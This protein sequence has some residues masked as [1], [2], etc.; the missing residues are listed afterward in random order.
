[1]YLTPPK[2]YKNKKFKAESEESDSIYLTLDELEKIHNFSPTFED[3]RLITKEIREHNLKRKLEVIIHDKNAFLIGTFTLQRVSDYSRIKDFNFQRDFIR[4]K[5]IKGSSKN[6]D[7]VV[8]R[9]WIITEIIESGF[10]FN[11]PTYDQKINANIK[12]VG[13][14]LGFNTP[15]PITMTEGGQQGQRIYP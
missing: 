10:D 2:G 1:M 9:H 3:L 13:R 15:T 11:K 5:S 12:D 8:P 7:I 6:D 4:Y 14:M